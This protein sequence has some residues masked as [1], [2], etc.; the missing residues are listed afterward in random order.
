MWRM[1]AAGAA[2][3]ALLVTAPS[4]PPAEAD[5]LPPGGTFFDD[6]GNVHESQ[7]E[8][9][10][11]IG[12]TR[13]CSATVAD[14]YCPGRAVTRGEMAAFLVR[15]LGL[16]EGAVGRF[17]DDD[18]SMFE[19]DIEKLAAAGVTHGCNPPD[20]DRFCPDRRVTRGEMAALLVRAF[21][22]RD[23]SPDRFV[24][25]DHSIF[26]DDIEKLAAA[27]VTLGCNPPNNDRFCA[28]EPVRRDHMASFLTRA[29]QL[30][31][32]EVMPRPVVTLA[33]TGD[34]LIH[35][36]VTW[37]A[38]A[39]GD[40]SG[41]A[42]DFRPM[43]EPVRSLL[44]SADVALCHLE[45]PL[46]AD[47]SVLSGYP[48]FSAPG[49]LA[50]ALAFAGYDGCST[51]SNHSIDQGVSGLAETL[52]V[53]DAAGLG[54]AGTARTA[55]EAEAITMYEAAGMRIAHLSATWSLNGLRLPADMPWAA[56]MI[57]LD[58]L[59][60]QAKKARSEGADFVVV[61]LHCCLEYVSNPS[62]EQLT[63]GRTLIASADIDLVVG[64]HAHVV[65]PI[66]Q[67]GDEF[68]VYGLGNFLSGQL[69]SDETRDG[70][71]VRAEIV[72]RG[73]RWVTR[74]IGYTPTWVSGSNYY[75]L[76]AAEAVDAG[77]PTA[78]LEADL[79]ASWRRTTAVLERLGVDAKPTAVP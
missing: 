41:Q 35:L 11:A 28:D 34:T 70:V 56:E 54:H 16:K 14:L 20:N 7:I 76:A 65:Q 2:A 24:D 51:A 59:R 27:G 33:M 50:D 49:S 47:A 60:A 68:I 74:S 78:A 22:Y 1:V 42:Y 32:I 58:R 46:S 64:H 67:V 79:I 39:Y 9:I 45:V 21:G 71:I 37:R 12:I 25:D 23:P 26:E 40:D 3:M 31:P 30:D 5:D 4:A 38:A 75:V 53:M 62:V 15:A 73:E 43:F 66:E 77:W 13:G 61:S 8:A 10:A 63:N 18:G 55:A 57:D 48:L 36:P 29:L 72:P 69:W 17:V 6:D 44:E 19:E 52:D